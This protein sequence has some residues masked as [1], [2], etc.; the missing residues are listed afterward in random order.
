[1]APILEKTGAVI[2]KVNVDVSPKIA[3]DHG[4]IVIPSFVFYKDG[5]LRSSHIGVM[6]A[7]D[8]EW[9]LK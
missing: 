4:I 3:Y 2:V 1:M 6:A 7:G 5:K 9:R 8:I